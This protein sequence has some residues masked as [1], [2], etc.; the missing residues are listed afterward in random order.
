M[1][2]KTDLFSG[3][4]ILLGIAFYYWILGSYFPGKKI[5]LSALIILNGIGLMVHIKYFDSYKKGTYVTFMGYL[6]TLGFVLITTALEL[7]EIFK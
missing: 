3:V 6:A 7:L 1:I 2:R 5:V 4:I